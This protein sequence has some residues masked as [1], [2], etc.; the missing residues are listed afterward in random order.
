MDALLVGEEME[1]LKPEAST[2]GTD[3][4]SEGEA[5]VFD[6][7]VRRDDAHAN[8]SEE[9][10]PLRKHSGMQVL[11]PPQEEKRWIHACCCCSISVNA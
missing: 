7:F 4:L 10:S 11:Q 5:E 2:I 1:G 9:S 3:G 6:G 8:A